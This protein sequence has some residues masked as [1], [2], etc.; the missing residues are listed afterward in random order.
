MLSLLLITHV[1]YVTQ[2]N[3]VSARVNNPAN[4]QTHKCF[5]VAT[6]SFLYSTASEVIAISLQGAEQLPAPI[7]GRN[8][9]WQVQ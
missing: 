8:R 7:D 5:V 2:F 6:A 9:Q 3:A 4:K 1:T